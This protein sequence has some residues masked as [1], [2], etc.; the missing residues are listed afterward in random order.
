MDAKKKNS[1]STKLNNDPDSV[2]IEMNGKLKPKPIALIFR[3]SFFMRTDQNSYCLLLDG[4]FFE[5]V[6]S[7]ENKEKRVYF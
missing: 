2:K 7:L 1:G 6:C 4:V 3:F 5:I